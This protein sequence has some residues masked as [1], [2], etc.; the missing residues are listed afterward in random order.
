MYSRESN[1]NNM[2]QELFSQTDF[3]FPDI[4][5]VTQREYGTRQHG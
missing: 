3:I 5:A 1:I 2:N 4:D